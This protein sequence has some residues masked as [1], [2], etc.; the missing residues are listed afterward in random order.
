VV[1]VAVVL[2][3][4]FAFAGEYGLVVPLLISGVLR[5]WEGVAGAALLTEGLRRPGGD[6]LTGEAVRVVGLGLGEGEGAG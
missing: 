1:T 2:V 6:V 5:G 3:G 4:Q